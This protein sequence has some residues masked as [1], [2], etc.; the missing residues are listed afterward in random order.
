MRKCVRC[1]VPMKEGLVAKAGGYKLQ[2]S[3]DAL[4]EGSLGVLKYAVCP[5]CGQVETY[6]DQTDKI[7]KK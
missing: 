5:T 7:K 3:G 4:F 2:L 6:L 1:D